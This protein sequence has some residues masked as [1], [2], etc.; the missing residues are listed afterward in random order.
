MPVVVYYGEESYLLEQAAER[1]RQMVVNP[2]MASLC[3]R[4]YTKPS[5]ATVL[6]AVG[7]VSLALGGQT[8]V[9]IRDFAL[10]HEAS[11]DAGTDT[12]LEAL[13]ALLENV[14][15]TKTVLFLSTKLDGKIRFPKWL[16]KHSTF[17]I[18]K[19]ESFKFWETDKV[20]GF[21]LHHA[22]GSGISL[23]EEAA[24]LLV[25]NMGTDLRLLL[26]EVEK[27]SLYAQNRP[28][29]RDDVLLVSSHSDN[30]FQLINRW[31]LGEKPQPNFTDLSELLLKRHAIEIFATM[32][33]HFNKNFRV[34]WLNAQGHRPHAIAQQTGQKPYPIENILKQFRHVPLSRWLR[35]KS[36]M[37]DMEWR[38]K[39]GQLDSQLALE[40]LLGA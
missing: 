32:Q 39:T 17:T 12:Q 14:E 25:N 10:L 38:A 19:F 11:K 20:V 36:L 16:S 8:L 9:E 40:I 15:S 1:L 33:T 3:H 26:G 18:Q 4:V 13:K 6:E 24:E 7:S 30:L 34:V 23:T 29:T 22:K 31:I 27:L 28:I 35:L 21:L 37:V 2:A 5:L